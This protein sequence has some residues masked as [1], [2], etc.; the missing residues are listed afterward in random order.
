LQ[1]LR[2]KLILRGNPGEEDYAKKIDLT[3]L[4]LFSKKVLSLLF[5]LCVIWWGYPSAQTLAILGMGI[6]LYETFRV[7]KK[8]GKCP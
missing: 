5:P 4:P 2:G 6:M 8:Y 1:I 7:V 3:L